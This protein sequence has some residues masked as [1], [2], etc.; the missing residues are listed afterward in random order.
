MEKAFEEDAAEG[1]MYKCPLAQ[2]QRD[3]PGPLLRI[4]AQ[5]ALEKGENSWRIVH[6]ATHGVGINRHIKPR[7]QLAS[8]A[9]AELRCLVELARLQP[10]PHF[11]LK[12]DVKKAHRR[13]LHRPSD[14]GLLGCRTGAGPNVTD[15]W[16]N[17]VGTF[18]V[19][20]AAYWW[21]RLAAAIARIVMA[22][23]GKRFA[24]QVIYVDD[25]LLTAWGVDKYETLLLAVA[26]WMMAG[27]PFSWKK[28]G[29]GLDVDYIGYSLSLRTYELGI[30]EGRARWLV[31]FA[32]KLVEDKV[33]LVRSLAGWLGRVGYAAGVL[34]WARPFLGPIYAW[35][36]AAPGGATLPVPEAVLLVVA[37]VAAQLKAGGRVTP[38][39][40][41]EVALGELFRTDAK[42][43]EG[44]VVLG[45]WRTLGAAS[46][47]AAE[48]FS[49]EVGPA[50]APWLF[51][52]G[53]AS[54]A[55]SAAE[56]LATKV[57]VQLWAPAAEARRGATRL[58]G[59]TDN[60]GNSH[61]ILKQL[62]TKMPV[63]AV[64]MQLT[65]DLHRAGL[66]LDLEWVPREENTEAD[67][68][69]NEDFA[70][71][72]PSLRIPITWED[73]DLGVVRDVLAV[74]RSFR[75][76]LGELKGARAQERGTPGG[77]PPEAEPPWP[78]RPQG[79][80][81]KRQRLD[82]WV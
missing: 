3:F 21:S 66:S 53:Q 70:L 81:P 36:A 56:L 28:T 32:E 18:G 1:M 35:S 29:G 15:V 40:K 82:A 37:W 68:L 78:R 52:A 64:L 47:A 8:P 59:L 9:G 5:A 13:F 61:I 25:L 14:W 27:A 42:G 20:S 26:L 2:A 41:A 48:W 45:G 62:T 10:G 80:G 57:A 30:S 74:E 19:G 76:Q 69:T 67:A 63:A 17:R 77:G 33:A 23:W 46:P 16:I 58:T 38:C 44:R 43:E 34:E 11:L 54:A 12:L 60:K 39:R 51:R 7:D 22:L 71:F 31:D 6:D 73:V 65:T 24:F 79:R 4:A 75:E 72:I 55:I 50:Q 49:L